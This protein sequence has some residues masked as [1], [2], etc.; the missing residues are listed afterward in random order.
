MRMCRTPSEFTSCC[1]VRRPP[2]AGAAAA[3]AEDRHVG[4]LQQQGLILCVALRRASMA[5]AC[6]LFTV[7]RLCLWVMMHLVGGTGCADDVAGLCTYSLHRKTSVL[8][9]TCLMGNAYR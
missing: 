9:F 6:G 5:V 8:V 4:C 3:P 2:D 1:H 7:A